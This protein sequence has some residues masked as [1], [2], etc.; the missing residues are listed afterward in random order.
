MGRIAGRLRA[1]A[2]ALGAP[3]LFLIA[4][5]DSSFL[6]LPEIADLL[7]VYMVTHHKSRVLLYAVSATLGSIA[8]CLVMY[9]IGKK[10][11]DALMRRRFT[12]DKVDRA[13]RL[14]QRHGVIA[15]LVPSLL[16]PPAPFKIFVLIAGVAHIDVRKFVLA[17]AIGRG[18][19]YL[20]LGVLAVEYG[21][22]A[23][24]YMHENSV[25]A[26]LIAVG[27]LVA[28]FVAYLIWSKRS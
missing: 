9:Y 15:V 12:G 6:S 8:G 5:L 13:M 26:S 27:I 18:V 16:P 3:G 24:A 1:L 7:V 11:G 22:R 23:L 2:L 21:D 20:L 14:F 25:T 28:G 10:G 19:R 17:V 4:F